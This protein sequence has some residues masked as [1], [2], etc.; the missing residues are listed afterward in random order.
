ML[1][2]PLWRGSRFLSVSFA[3]LLNGSFVIAVNLLCLLSLVREF[4]YL[5]GCLVVG[6]KLVDEKDTESDYG[7]QNPDQELRPECLLHRSSLTN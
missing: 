4:V 3:N 5:Y 6:T 7:G 2:L 1:Q